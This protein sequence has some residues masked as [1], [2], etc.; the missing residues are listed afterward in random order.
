MSDYLG[1]VALPSMKQRQ[2]K[3]CQVKMKAR[4]EPVYHDSSNFGVRML[5]K[6]GWSEGKGLGKREDGMAA[7]ILPK[8]KQDIEGFG[9][10]GEKDDHW[11]QHDQDFNQLLLSLNGGD[12]HP[13]MDDADRAKIKSLEEKSKNSRARV[14]YKKFT[15][16][17]DLSRASEKDLANIFG[18]RS[19]EEIK[20]PVEEEPDQQKEE[21]EETNILGLTTIQSSMSLQDYFKAKMKQK[22]IGI[23]PDTEDKTEEPTKKKKRVRNLE[24]YEGIE[25]QNEKP[26][27]DESQA[28]LEASPTESTKK[29]RKRKQVDVMDEI[30]LNEEDPNSKKSTTEIENESNAQEIK[31]NMSLQEY[32]KKKLKEKLSSSKSCVFEQNTTQS[33]STE[34]IIK[35]KNNKKV[36]LETTQEFSANEELVELPKK[37]KKKSKIAMEDALEV[38]NEHL[39]ETLRE[40]PPKKKSKK[41][42]RKP[43]TD[44]ACSVLEPNSAVETESQHK[45]SKKKKKQHLE[46]TESKQQQETDNAS[47]DPHSKKKKK[48]DV[49]E[50]ADDEITCPVKATD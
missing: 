38:L 29:K 7:P 48:K 30:T 25:G 4:A 20:S 15:R 11:T 14:H 16:G 33:S 12:K 19:L 2:K 10:A 47:A 45:K 17:K 26:K 5:E 18:K 50:A 34:E 22:S 31:S 41:E 46:D 49:P 1:S 27:D 8:M 40:E 36:E 9:Y 21:H 23:Q 28:I 3:L 13:G 35:K 43:S 6:L 44:E 37:K 42:K 24:S 39:A 32:F